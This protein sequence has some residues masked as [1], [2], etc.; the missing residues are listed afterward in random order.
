[1]PHRTYTGKSVVTLATNTIIS[2][3]NSLVIILCAVLR[4]IPWQR[5]WFSWDL[6]RVAALDGVNSKIVLRCSWKW[7]HPAADWACTGRMEGH[8]DENEWWN[9]VQI[10]SGETNVRL[11]QTKE[12][13][14][15]DCVWQRVTLHF[16]AR[17]ADWNEGLEKM[18]Y[19]WII[20]VFMQY[21]GEL[22]S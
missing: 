11:R 16:E 9:R 15:T 4:W 14:R 22:K 8:K 17:Q 7:F 5:P 10:Q 2:R 3:R 19:K 12:F 13:V 21:R 20:F 18:T 1:M 6:K